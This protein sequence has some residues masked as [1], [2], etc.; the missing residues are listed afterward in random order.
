[1]IISYSEI[2]KFQTCKRQ[3]FYR[4]TKG[5]A[6]LEESPA[7]STGV[8]GHKLLENF[9]EFLKAGKTKEEARELTTQSAMD[10]IK[11]EGL[12]VDP[13][14][15]KAWTLV[16]NYITS[17]KHFNEAIIIENRFLIPATV[18]GGDPS[19]DQVMI[20]FTPDVVLERPGN[21]L[22]VEDAKFVGRAWSKSKL[23]RFQQAKL[24]QIFLKR[25]GYNVTRSSVRFFNV[26]TGNVS[27]QNYTMK[28]QE[29]AIL[30]ERF[31]CWSY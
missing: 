22:D 12:A 1:M 5:L 19:L 28:A 9:Y 4:F 10:L 25:M 29:E 23:N 16:D 26:T 3:Y 31:Y 11:R 7:I 2:V 30:I 18:I 14:L 15:L 20:G 24:Y 13:T 6:P 8:K 21:M 27:V 17:T